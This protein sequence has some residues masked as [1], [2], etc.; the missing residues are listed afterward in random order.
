MELKTPL[1]DVHVREKGKI[2]PFAG[3]LLPVQYEGVITEHLAVRKQAGLFDVSHMGEITIKGPGALATLN[4]LLANDFTRMSTGKVRYSVMCNENGGCVDDLL[5]YKFGEEDYFL[6]VNASNRHKDFEHMKKNILPDTEIE[7]ISD[8]LAQVALQGPNSREIMKKVMKEEDIPEKYYTAKR[9][10]DIGGMDCIISYTGYTGEA[11]Y[12]IYTANENAE[13]MWDLLRENGKEFGLIPC[14]LGARD[15]LR[16]EASMPLYGHEMDEVVSP[17]ETGLD[18]GVK[19]DKEEFIGKQALLDRGE[20]KICR[21][22]LTILD[23]GV[24]R[25]HQDVYIG[26]EKIG[27]TTSG[28]FSPLLKTSIAMALIDKKHSALDTVV[29]VD[30]RGRRLKAK[31]VEMPFYTRNR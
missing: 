9:N 4:H 18:F 27:H 20:P 12:E 28:T 21:V 7:D 5:V 15:T 24:L 23:R 31:I 26:D 8:T 11:G 17:L 6:V 3:Y 19:M 14:G 29:E 2:V 25:E 16:L 13:K 1:Y 30:V 22:G 10:V